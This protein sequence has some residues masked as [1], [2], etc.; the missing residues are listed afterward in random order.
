MMMLISLAIVAANVYSVLT[1]FFIS[2]MNYYFELAEND[3]DYV[4]GTLHY[5]NTNVSEGNAV[6]SLAKLLPSDAEVI[7][8][9]QQK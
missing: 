3:I 5:E 2:G 8:E 9:D 6:E 4:G 7:H 1:T